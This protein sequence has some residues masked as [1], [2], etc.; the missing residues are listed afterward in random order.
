MF[1]VGEISHRLPEH[2]SDRL[3][4]YLPEKGSGIA[5][6]PVQIKSYKG[7]IGSKQR[8]TAYASAMLKVTFLTGGGA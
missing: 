6:L 4:D 2:L 7:K 3:V 1:I 8:R 5:L